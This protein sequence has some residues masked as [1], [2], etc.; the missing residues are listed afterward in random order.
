MMENKN[1]QDKLLVM[2]TEIYD[3]LEELEGALEQSL[4]DLRSNLYQQQE[5]NLEFTNTKL[6]KVEI[7]LQSQKPMVKGRI[8]IPQV[9]SKSLKLE[10][11]Y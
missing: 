6:E 10:M 2:L 1:P 8:E 7:K 5:S 11:G 4:T 3:Q 9:P